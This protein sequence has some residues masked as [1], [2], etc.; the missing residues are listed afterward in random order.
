MQM[1]ECISEPCMHMHALG[2]CACICRYLGNM[3]ALENGARINMHVLHEFE[4]VPANACTKKSCMHI[5]AFVKLCMH[6]QAIGKHAW[7]LEW[8][9]NVNAHKNCAHICMHL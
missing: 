3:L 1:H 2:N 4:I 7:I 8:F 6:I 5:H 9:E